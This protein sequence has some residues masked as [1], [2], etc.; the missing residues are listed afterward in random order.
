MEAAI[1]K[2][3]ISHNICSI[4]PLDPQSKVF[5][6]EKHLEIHQTRI[7]IAEMKRLEVGVLEG[8]L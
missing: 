7:E 2:V 1:S 4:K 3:T 5:T 6:L 8:K